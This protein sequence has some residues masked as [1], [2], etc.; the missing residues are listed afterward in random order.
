[1]LNLI[2]NMDDSNHQ[3]I[4]ALSTISSYNPQSTEFCQ[5][6]N[7]LIKYIQNIYI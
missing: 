1:M 7:V 4:I 3:F 6:K 5:C 2:V